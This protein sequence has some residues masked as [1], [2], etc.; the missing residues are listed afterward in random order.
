MHNVWTVM[1]KELKRFFTDKRVLL[2]LILPGIVIFVMYSIMGNAM[3]G[4]FQVDENYEY[5]VCAVNLPESFKPVFESEAYEIKLEEANGRT[6]EQLQTA[7]TEKELDAYLVFEENF[8]EKV[9]AGQKPS[10]SVYYNSTKAESSSVYSYLFESL[11]RPSAEIEFKYLVNAGETAYDLATDE[12]ISATFLT[13]LLPFLLVILLF[14]GCMAVSTEAI[15]GEKERGTIATLLVT[16]VSRPHIALGKLLALAVTSLFSATV[17]FIGL[18][19]AMP[20]FAKG[21][22]A[23]FTMGMYG[24]GAY[25]GVFAVMLVTVLLF[26]ALLSLLST[27]ANSVKEASQLSMPCMV[28]VM[29][30]GLSS[31]LGAGAATNPWLY[32]IPVYNSVQCLNGIF[33]LTFAPLDFVLTV[34][35]NLVYFALGTFLLAKFFGSEKIMFHK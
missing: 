33:G 23:G 8:E 17:S 31:M 34:V 22:G 19:G 5:K 2:T 6:H 1:K 30:I 12:D 20:Q 24:I 28:L 11:Y 3:E 7:V 10:V 26:T 9:A 18:V 4:M 29:V 27:L 14:S 32:L 15:A 25:L 35:S 16:P 13:N 21:M